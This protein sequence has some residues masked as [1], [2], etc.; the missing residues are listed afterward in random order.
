MSNGADQAEQAESMKNYF[1]ANKFHNMFINTPNMALALLVVLSAGMAFVTIFSL[2]VTLVAAGILGWRCFKAIKEYPKR[3][4]MAL[5]NLDACM[6]EI[7]EFDR[8]YTEKRQQKELLINQ[9][10]FI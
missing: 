2:I 4:N 5:A 7:A 6:A 9:V 8:Y 10:E 1:E 3:V